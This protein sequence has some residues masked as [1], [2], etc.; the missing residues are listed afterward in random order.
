MSGAKP[1]LSKQA[2]ILAPIST[3]ELLDKITI[4]EIKAQR[5]TD[6]GKLRNVDKELTTLRAVVG[7]FVVLDDLGLGLMD[8]LREINNALWD[9]EDKLREYETR[10]DFGEHF[11]QL[12]R[13]VYIS[14]DKR[15][16]VKKKLNELTGSVLVEEKSY[17]VVRP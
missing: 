3:G 11:I 10:Q 14:N 7:E 16:L 4:L 12:A 2:P 5:I 1:A 15:A 17:T 6:A 9:V 8:E 13:S